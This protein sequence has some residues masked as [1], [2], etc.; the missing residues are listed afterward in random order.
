M[1]AIFGFVY[2][3]LEKRKVHIDD[4]A[5]LKLAV[6]A[7]KKYAQEIQK[8][9]DVMQSF[10]EKLCPSFEQLRKLKTAMDE[11]GKPCCVF[12]LNVGLSGLVDSDGQLIATSSRESIQND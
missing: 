1:K 8:A 7:A 6:D 4:A 2:D 10:D 12:T 3:L 11:C 9:I 5:R